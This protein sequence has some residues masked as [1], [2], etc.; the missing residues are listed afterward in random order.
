MN[1]IKVIMLNKKSAQKIVNKMME[2]VLYNI[3]VMDNEARIIGSGDQSRIGTHHC[4]AAEALK[5]IPYEAMVGL[6]M[7]IVATIIYG[8]I[9]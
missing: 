4:G 6:T 2:V 1:I 5:L 9:M 3:N 7:T 8:I